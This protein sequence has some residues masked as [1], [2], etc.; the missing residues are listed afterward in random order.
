MTNNR[1]W[2]RTRGC[3]F[4]LAALAGLGAA[5]ALAAKGDSFSTRDEVSAQVTTILNAKGRLPMPVQ[6]VRK[7]LTKHYVEN[8]GRL[9]WVGSPRMDQ[10]IEHLSNAERDGLFSR[11][12][13]VDYLIT[14]KDSLQA[15]ESFTEAYA[16]LAFSAFFLRYA[17]DLKIG[18]FVP[19]KIDPELFVSRKKL[20]L[21]PLLTKLNNYSSLSAFFK[22][23]EPQNSEYR[24]L[25]NALRQFQAIEA[26]GGWQ[27]VDPGETLKP[28]M[29]DPRVAQV[30][31]RLRASGDISQTATD[32]NVYDE[33]LVI[34]VRQF[35]AEHGLDS[36]GVIG[37]QSIFAMNIP[38]KERVRQIIVNLERWRW[39]PEDLGDKHILV[40]VASFELRR[41]E[42]GSLQEVIRVVVGK[43]GHRTPV[44]SNK[45]KYLELNPTWTVPYSI[46]TKEILPKLQ[47]NPGHLGQSYELLQG[48]QSIPFG[49][50]DWASYSR[51]S[52]PFTIRQKPGPKNALGRVKFI[53]PN[54]HS[55]YLHDTPSRS[56]FS[57]TSRAFS[58]GCIRVGR[59]LHLANQLLANAPGKW[60]LR[61]IQTVLDSA[62]RTRVNLPE[63]LAVHLTYSTVFRGLNGAINFRP[64]I[65]GRD[66]RLYR[67]LFAKHTP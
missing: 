64:D 44:F 43:P 34:A 59:P 47:A 20:A 28:G 52:F 7:V 31:A 4:A 63:P 33:A 1:T 41:V 51:S 22:D 26:K 2:D 61:K 38:A 39:L 65:Y 54:K 56:L 24:T 6:R 62:K 11:D 3:A 37:K 58:H 40:N 13:P 42:Y 29:T 10:L 67:A 21:V 8:E 49:S 5:P 50:V 9:F 36:D 30:R 15:G 25:R 66:K 60:S 53:F 46:A 19:R 32:P 14:L 27:P 16:E 18:R 12:Y 23:M 17:T 57:R 48:G 45:I 35:Q 55:I